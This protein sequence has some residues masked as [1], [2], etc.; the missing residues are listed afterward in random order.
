MKSVVVSIIR[1][2]LVIA[3]FALIHPRCEPEIHVTTGDI[4]LV[5]GVRVPLQ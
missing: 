5:S 4:S 1:T 2:S 3:G